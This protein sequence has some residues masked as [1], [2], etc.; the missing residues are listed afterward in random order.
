M[1]INDKN[2]RTQRI[3]MKN[4]SFIIGKK[5]SSILP[6]QHLKLPR[7]L[8]ADNVLFHQMKVPKDSV[9][10]NPKGEQKY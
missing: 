6:T 10:P 9:S 3:G 8:S 1:N 2:E 5:I 7:E 4:A